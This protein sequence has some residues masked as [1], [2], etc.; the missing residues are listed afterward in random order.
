MVHQRAV[1]FDLDGT[2]TD[3]LPLCYAAFAHAFA[4]FGLPARTDPQ[5]HALFGPS[6][7]GILKQLLPDRWQ[8]CYE[9]YL[10]FYEEH[11]D[12]YA[13]IFPGIEPLLGWVEATQ[14]RTGIVTAKGAESAAITIR[15]LGLGRYFS[16]IETGSPE[17]ANKPR[18]I[19]AMLT[20]WG[21]LP[22]E[23][24]YVGDSPYDMRASREVGVLPLGAAWADGGRAPALRSAGA[25]EVFDTPQALRAWLQG[26]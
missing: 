24:V 8:A 5:I 21:R 12:R 1:I 6:E 11:H 23:A 2:L 13:R 14:L 4:R 19:T 7:E 16:D 25:A 17:G 9:V 26:S 18:G 3:T 22:D 20:R 15:R 10:R